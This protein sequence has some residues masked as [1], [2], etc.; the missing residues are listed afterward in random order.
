MD[1]NLKLIDCSFYNPCQISL[2]LV[3]VQILEQNWEN[4]EIIEDFQ[5]NID[6]A[7]L[8]ESS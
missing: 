2:A 8:S 1:K 4:Y 7:A 3:Y 6:S 5:K